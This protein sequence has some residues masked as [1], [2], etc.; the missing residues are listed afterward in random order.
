MKKTLNIL[1]AVCTLFAFTACGNPNQ[2]SDDAA[3]QAEV[4]K[5]VADLKEQVSKLK[6]AQ[7]G[8]VHVP[9]T[10][11]TDTTTTDATAVKPA[12]PESS[13]TVD[14][15]KDGDKIDADPVTFSGTVSAG[16]TKIVATANKGTKTEDV[17]TL[18][19]FKSGDLKFSYKASKSFSNMVS[20]SNTYEFTAYFKDGTTKTTKLT[21]NFS[22]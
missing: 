21:I 15:H 16:A 19:S 2:A 10:P 6:D 4:Q 7:D 8:V 3:K 17:Y 14:N 5:Q 11:K 9:A 12:V 18:N 22:K 20:G 13:I 1:L